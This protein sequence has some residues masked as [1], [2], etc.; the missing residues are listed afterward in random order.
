MR[1]PTTIYISKGAKFSNLCLN[2]NQSHDKQNA[3][4]NVSTSEKQNKTDQKKIILLNCAQKRVNQFRNR[5][6]TVIKE[7]EKFSVSESHN[8]KIE[9]NELEDSQGDI[10]D[11]VEDKFIKRIHVCEA[12]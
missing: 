11:T 7:E 9:D 3:N 1:T 5:R 2:T 8:F 10:E 6:F 12:I 4:N